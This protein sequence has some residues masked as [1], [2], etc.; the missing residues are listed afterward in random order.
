MKKINTLKVIDGVLI[1]RERFKAIKRSYSIDAEANHYAKRIIKNAYLESE[2]IKREAFKDGLFRGFMMIFEDVMAHLDGKI[3]I[4]NEM[5]TRCV[6]EAKNEVLDLIT[7]SQIVNGMIAEWERNDITPI[8][9]NDELL[10][11]LG[12]DCIHLKSVI[13]EYFIGKNVKVIFSFSD[14]SGI[15]IKKHEHIFR[16]TPENFVSELSYTQLPFGSELTDDIKQVDD[17]LI[18][19]IIGKLERM[20]GAE[21]DQHK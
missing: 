5:K 21:N 17:N 7:H 9:K 19:S 4:E 6:N 3:Q 8:L 13:E 1:T 12:A 20:K 11:Q 2:I 15:K 14:S 16:F 10:I 18:N